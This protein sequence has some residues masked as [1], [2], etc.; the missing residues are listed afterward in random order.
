MNE[1]KDY[2]FLHELA[3]EV[4]KQLRKAHQ[5]KIKGGEE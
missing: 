2:N 3:V 1:E 4:R 5:K